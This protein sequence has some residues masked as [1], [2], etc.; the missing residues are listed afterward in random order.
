MKDIMI[1]R[2]VEKKY[3][4]TPTQ[5]DALLDC[6]GQRLTPDL[7]GRNTIC[8]LY[9]DTPDHRIIRNSII[10]KAYKEKLR[11]R[12]YGTPGAD[13]LVFLEIKKKYK[14]VVYK[15]RERMTLRQAMAYVER[16]EQPCDS[17]IMREIDYAMRFYRQPQP[18]MLVAY[19]RDAYF[20]A[21][22]P[23]LRITFDMNCRARDTNCRLDAGHHGIPLLP[24]EEIIMEIKTDGAM[25]L[26]LAQALSMCGILPARFSKYG[27]AYLRSTGLIPTT[28]YHQSTDLKGE[29]TLHA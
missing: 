6:I 19:E 17:Q 12:S 9:L 8:S 24:P 11:I 26:W 25:P 1:F 22:N 27:T 10:A 29:T 2:R 23:N 13:D 7:H 14:G 5:R 3:R 15:R 16:G 21:D 20:D 4:L 28:D 18:A